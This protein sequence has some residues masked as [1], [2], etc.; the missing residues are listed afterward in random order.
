[1]GFAVIHMEKGTTGKASG[2]GSHID[3]TKN[4][5]NADPELTQYNARIDLNNSTP[6]QTKWTKEKNTD[7]LQSRIDKRIKEGY[8]GQYSVTVYAAFV[9][10]RIS[11][12]ICCL[13]LS[14]FGSKPNTHINRSTSNLLWFIVLMVLIENSLRLLR[15]NE[16]Q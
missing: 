13:F 16:Y 14:M 12:L 2:L 7:T 1:M 9:P 11:S 3:R 4:V 15:G 6:E 5:P 10:Y 8:T